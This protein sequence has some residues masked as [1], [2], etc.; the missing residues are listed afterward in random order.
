M[1]LGVQWN[2]GE[3]VILIGQALIRFLPLD[4]PFCIGIYF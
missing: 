2:V 3:W 4:I 1:L